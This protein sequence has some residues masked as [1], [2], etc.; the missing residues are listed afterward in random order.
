M[1]VLVGLMMIGLVA[2]DESMNR[3]LLL[4]PLLYN[5]L[6]YSTE[7]RGPWR[8]YVAAQLISSPA[9]SVSR[10]GGVGAG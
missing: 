5:P 10:L 9:R 6:L 8:S 2:D 3:L 7:S 1:I 4:Q